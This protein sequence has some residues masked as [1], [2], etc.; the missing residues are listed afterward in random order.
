MSCSFT[1]PCRVAVFFVTALLVVATPA[2]GQQAKYVLPHRERVR[3]IAFSPD[4][5]LLGT[6]SSLGIIFWDVQ[7]GKPQS[8]LAV[9]N[10]G[11]E[12]FA[13]TP[14]GKRLVVAHGDS[15]LRVWNRASGAVELVI[16]LPDRALAIALSPDGKRVATGSAQKTIRIWDLVK[17]KEVQTILSAHQ[18][19]AGCLGFSPDGSQLASGGDDPE[20]K[21]WDTANG[22][23]RLV[24]P[25]EGRQGHWNCLAF[26]P[27][28]TK[29]ASAGK[30]YRISDAKKGMELFNPEARDT[31][32]RALSFNSSGKWV[33]IGGD[34]NKVS[35]LNVE[36]GRLVA[37]LRGHEH[38]INVVAFSRDG[39]YLASASSDQ[40]VR[41]WD[42]RQLK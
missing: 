35:I 5:K 15:S 40:T 27:D 12:L 19:G 42:L 13:F 4:S 25:A 10:V 16:A 28:G 9:T 2:L 21:I 38:D 1:C 3:C 22:R 31:E 7:K 34:D 17:G 36:T 11:F 32:Y 39:K 24:I 29:L 26:S 33:A 8:T 23:S 37:E 30:G 41:I 6:L 14:D 20:I 18:R